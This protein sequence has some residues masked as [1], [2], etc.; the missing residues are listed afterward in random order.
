M[1]LC[2]THPMVRR[3]WTVELRPGP[4]RGG[5][6]L[7][8]PQCPPGSPPVR[9]AASQ[10]LAHLARHARH[11][12]LPRHLRTCQ[13][14][15]HGCRWHPRHRGCSGPVLLVLTREH[16]GRLWRLAD[17]CA[18]CAA[19]TTHAAVVP[20]TVLAP[21]PSAQSDKRALQKQRKTR[22]SGPSEQVRVQQML[23]YLAA[24]LP[25][26]TSAPARL[27]ALQCALRSTAAGKVEI[28]TGL[29][30]GMRL[31][32][33]ATALAEL[34]DARWLYSP[35]LPGGRG[36]GFTAQLLDVAVRM[37][38][39]TIKDRSRAADWILRT[40]QRKELRE[41]DAFSRLLALALSVHVPSGQPGAPASA[42]QEVLARACGLP[43]PGIVDL[44][45]VLVRA[46]FLRSWAH[47]P[48]PEDLRW[49]LVLHGQPS[50]E[51]PGLTV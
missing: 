48:A 32:R 35:T 12:A 49:E 5:P 39:P 30:R 20:D 11:D 22:R 37:Q 41:L 16:G 19:A 23:S 29:V 42:E 31:G 21:A 2:T 25:A 36:G 47:G 17:V 38:A 43:A 27:L 1:R 3:T 8:C 44:L 7:H 33:A 46:R 4:E 10:A 14:H 45:D 9:G 34:Q 26:Q 24:A 40:C 51:E 18:A 6:V 13:C 28:P 15:P 50:C